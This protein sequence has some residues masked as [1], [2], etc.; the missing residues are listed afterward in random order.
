MNAQMLEK[1]ILNEA[2]DGPYKIVDLPTYGFEDP[3]T[4]VYRE[5]DYDESV[6]KFQSDNPGAIIHDG[7]GEGFASVPILPRPQWVTLYLAVDEISRHY[8][9]P[10][11]GGWWYDCGEPVEIEPIRV[12]YNEQGEAYLKESDREFLGKLAE[13]WAKD[14]DFESSHRSSM[15]PRAD[16]Y[17]WRVEWQMPK[18]W[19]SRRPYYE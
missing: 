2:K 17:N 15:A 10:E 1:A 5:L 14:Y 4:G 16:D 19:P 8:G 18:H 3:V 13:K 11:E 12:W 9:G 6:E 7:Y